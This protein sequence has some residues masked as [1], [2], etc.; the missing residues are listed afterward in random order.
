[1]TGPLVIDANVLIAAM[2]KDDAHH[3][4]AK[5]ILRSGAV[6]SR[7]IAHP[8]TIAES[9][10]GAARSGLAARLKMAYGG[11]GL[12]AT[13]ID[14]AGPWRAAQLRADTGLSLLDS[15]VLDTA[16]AHKGTLATFDQRLAATAV[17]KGVQ[18]MT[19]T[20]EAR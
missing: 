5:R 3:A 17:A 13:E 12:E 1:M 20:A 14:D 15:F 19:M 16:I 4:A 11:L 18:V 8:V 6:T 10:V 9:A 7:L 2:R